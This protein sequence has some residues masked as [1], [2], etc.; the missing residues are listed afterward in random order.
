M[1]QFLIEATALAAIGGVVGIIAGLGAALGV[2]ARFGW[3]LLVEPQSILGAVLFS[4]LVG[5]F[6]GWYP[7]RRA[8]RVDPVEA[9]RTE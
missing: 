2:S 4:G 9:L 3:P 5:V 8:S 1:R 6:F 7:A